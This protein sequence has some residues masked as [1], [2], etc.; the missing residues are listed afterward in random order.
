VSEGASVSFAARRFITGMKSLE[1]I[2]GAKNLQLLFYDVGYT[3][4]VIE[5]PLGGTV[6]LG[7]DGGLVS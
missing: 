3:P 7:G 6:A 1:E 5:F 4:I 2:E